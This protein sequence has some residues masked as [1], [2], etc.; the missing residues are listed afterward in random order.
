[1]QNEDSTMAKPISTPK[2]RKKSS[3]LNPQEPL[4]ERGRWIEKKKKKKER[5]RRRR[6]RSRR[7]SCVMAPPLL[8]CRLLPFLLFCV[9]VCV[10][11][12]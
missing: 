4:K 6:R 10:L 12:F 9:C 5:R 8:R 11:F 3:E 1:M 7:R 2:R